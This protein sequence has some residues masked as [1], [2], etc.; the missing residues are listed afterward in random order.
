[1][2]K[3]ILEV[4]LR[5]EKLLLKENSIPVEK[6]QTH[7]PWL[8]MPRRVRDAVC[9]ACEDGHI[10][11]KHPL[12]CED[13]MEIG[14]ASIFCLK[15]MGEVGMRAIDEAMIERGFSGWMKGWENERI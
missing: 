3:E 11:K 13:L 5:I 10:N 7:F 1:M 8:E 9:R 12:S 14:S 2:E 6:K 15:N 4:L